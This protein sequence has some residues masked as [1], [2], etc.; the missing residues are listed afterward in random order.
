MRAEGL[1]IFLP[2]RV[3]GACPKS[4]EVRSW[5]GGKM[6]IQDGEANKTPSFT[7]DQGPLGNKITSAGGQGDSY[8]I[9]LTL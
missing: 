6:N 5:G 2:D 7:Q 9:T 3:D 4:A 1:F 8:L